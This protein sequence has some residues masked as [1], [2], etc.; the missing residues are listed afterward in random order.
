MTTKPEKAT[1]G[2]SQFDPMLMLGGEFRCDFPRCKSK[3]TLTE[4]G[5][6]WVTHDLF[7][8]EVTVDYPLPIGWKTDGHSHFC[9]LHQITWHPV[10]VVPVEIT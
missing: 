10:V 3:A 4:C 6:A 9:H 8:R 5:D 7:G 1:E 2:K